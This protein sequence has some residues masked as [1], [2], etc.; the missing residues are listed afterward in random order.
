MTMMRRA[1]PDAAARLVL[2]PVEIMLLDRLVP[3]RQ[4]DP[5]GEQALS[6]YLAKVARLG[7]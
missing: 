1:A 7:G 4:Q 2:T 6:V 5:P 3:N